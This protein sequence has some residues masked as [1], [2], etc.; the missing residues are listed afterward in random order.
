MD[1]DAALGVHEEAAPHPGGGGGVD[2]GDEHLVGEGVGAGQ[3]GLLLAVAGGRLDDVEDQLGAQVGEV[4]GDLREPGVVADGQADAA[5]LAHLEDDELGAGRDPLVGAPGADLAV[6]GHPAALGRVHRGGVVDVPVRA[7]LVQAARGEPDTEV[8]GELA[9]PPVEGAV[10]RLGQF[11]GG[12]S[13]LAGDGAGG[14]R[15]EVE[16]GVDVQAYCR[17]LP[18]QSLQTGGEGVEVP[19]RGRGGLDEREREG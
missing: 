8:T 12:R 16:L 13:V 3:D 18:R 5:V 17:P 1:A 9:E 10:E 7:P 2:A 14:G 15:G 6:R 19:G 11:L 4:A